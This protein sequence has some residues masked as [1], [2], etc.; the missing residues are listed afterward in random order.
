MQEGRKALFVVLATMVVLAVVS[1]CAPK[2]TATPE[3]PVDHIIRQEVM[4]VVTT[5][6]EPITIYIS[7]FEDPD[8]DGFF[9]EGTGRLVSGYVKVYNTR[10]DAVDEVVV[11]DEKAEPFPMTREEVLQFVLLIPGGYEATT[12][13]VVVD[14]SS[15]LGRTS[16]IYFGLARIPTP[17][18]T[19]PPTATLTA[20][21]A[22]TS[23]PVPSKTPPPTPTSSTGGETVSVILKGNCSALQIDG[24]FIWSAVNLECTLSDGSKIRIPFAGDGHYAIPPN[25]IVQLW[26]GPGLGGSNWWSQWD[27][28]ERVVT[29]GEVTLR[30]VPVQDQEKPYKGRTP[31]PTLKPTRIANPTRTPRAA[32]PTPEGTEPVAPTN[33]PRPTLAPIPTAYPPAKTPTRGPM[34]Y[35]G[36]KA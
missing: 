12:S 1:G 21:A 22:P 8:R 25:S 5:T 18:P 24:E 3:P 28:Q 23:T 4:V 17:T 33:T 34:L 13:D 6:P 32:V 35:K 10:G 15:V 29:N 9:D 20:T 7:V 31:P 36:F 19:H 11:G 30:I 16:R 27:C 2:A 26:I 14:G